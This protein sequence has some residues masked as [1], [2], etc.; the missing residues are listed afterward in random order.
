MTFK[1]AI[2]HPIAIALSSI[3]LVGIGMAAG[4]GEP[5]HASVHVVLALAFGYAARYLRPGLAGGQGQAQ[6]ESVEAEIGDLRQALI[7]AQERMDFAERL[8][9]QG[10]EARRVAEE[11]GEPKP[12][13]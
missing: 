2:W 4:A 9:A 5:V 7:E 13:S 8:L 3:N 6:L 1:P 11:R 10:M 12:G